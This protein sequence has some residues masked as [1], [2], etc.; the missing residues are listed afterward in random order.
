MARRP[1]PIITGGPTGIDVDRRLAEL[2]FGSRGLILAVRD[3]AHAREG[4]GAS[5]FFPANGAGT[6]AYQY[7]TH[8]LRARLDELGWRLENPLGT[9]ASRH[10]TE[11]RRALYQNVDVACSL[12]N[13]PHPRTRKGVG[14][15][16]LAQSSLFPEEELIS[17]FDEAPRDCEAWY[18]MV[19][20]KGAVEVTNA[21]V[22]DGKFV[23][24]R[25]RLFV[26]DGSELSIVDEAHDDT[27]GEGAIEFD[28]SI[29]RK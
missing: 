16:R 4:E 6:L 19:D 29:A 14:A 28:I 10:P 22:R 7:G 21:V 12:A 17:D 24:F 20:E 23:E 3:V 9:A 5:P 15:E 18:V 2:G 13:D 8:E 1:T 27:D 26:D 25:E 11:A